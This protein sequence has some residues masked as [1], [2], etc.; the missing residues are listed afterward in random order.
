MGGRQGPWAQLC[1]RLRAPLPGPADPRAAQGHGLGPSAVSGLLHSGVF[2]ADPPPPSQ[3][4]PERRLGAPAFPSDPCQR[5]RGAMAADPPCGAASAGHAGEAAPGV[6][7]RCGQRPEPSPPPPAPA[8]GAG[9]GGA[10]GGLG[11]R[12]HPL[13]SLTERVY[14]PQGDHGGCRRGVTRL[15]GCWGQAG[16]A[17]GSRAVG[18]RRRSG[19]L[20]GWCP[21]C[22]SRLC[23]ARGRCRGPDPRSALARGAGM[24][25]Y[26]L[27]AMHKQGAA[28][29][30]PVEPA[31]GQSRRVTGPPLISL[32]T[33]A[34]DPAL[35]EA[36][37]SPSRPHRGWPPCAW[38]L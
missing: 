27:Q 13:P 26:R 32:G 22:E 28:Q 15:A 14:R 16:W 25:S 30:R 4:A 20:R 23:R 31:F 11:Y 38:H 29:A 21:A 8:R 33:A 19:R 1:P 35:G 3:P 24:T 17:A 7:G 10:R 9:A 37:R 2:Q 34:G 12:P 18:G 36:E 5:S 6:Q